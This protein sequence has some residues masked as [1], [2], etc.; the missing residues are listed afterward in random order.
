[1]LMDGYLVCGES[2]SFGVRVTCMDGSGTQRWSTR[3]PIHTAADALEWLCAAQLADGGVLLGGR[4]LT[5]E[6]AEA[7]QEGVLAL[8]SGD[9]VLR[10]IE[11]V[12]GAGAVCALEPMDGGSVTLHIASG[13]APSLQ[14]DGTRLYHP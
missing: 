13:A 3:I 6:G 4:Y 11:V 1:M 5:G 8:L 2:D 14:A 7:A 10:R 12:E 9:G